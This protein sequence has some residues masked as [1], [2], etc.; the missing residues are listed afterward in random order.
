MVAGHAVCCGKIL[1]TSGFC[2]N[3]PFGQAVPGSMEGRPPSRVL[4]MHYSRGASVYG[5]CLR[6][7]STAAVHGGCLRRQIS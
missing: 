3:K 4:T 6:R 1:D 7:L 5:G 2:R